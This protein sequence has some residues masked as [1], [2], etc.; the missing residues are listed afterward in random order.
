MPST[1]SR[2]RFLAAAGAAAAASLAGCAGDDA[3]DDTGTAGDAP[4]EWPTF[5]RDGRNANY[6]PSGTAPTDSPTERWRVESYRTSAQPVVADGVVYA[7]VGADVLAIDADSGERLWSV[8]PENDALRYWASPTV[9][10]GV[11]YLGDGDERLRAFDAATGELVWERTFD[12]DVFEGI[13]AAP[14]VGLRGLAVGT[15]GGTVYTLDPA[16]GETVWRT[17]VFGRIEST[18]AFDPPLFYAVT[19]G[20]DV[21]TFGNGGRGYWHVA[22]PGLSSTVPAAADGRCYVGC[23]DGKVYALAD[24]AVEWST[25]VGGFVSGGIAVAD[26]RVFV[27]GG[28]GLTVL[29]AESGD[30]R[31]SST[32]GDRYETPIVVG[33]TV[34][35]GGA[36][37][38]AVAVG[39]GIGVGAARFGAH[40]FGLS[41]SG[42]VG[43]IAAAD[44]LLVAG[45][46]EGPHDHFVAAF[47]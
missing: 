8:D 18:L 6:S 42:G 24:G 17:S 29:D 47:E 15:A 4:T 31:W 22:L 13:Y 35:V 33:E 32:V 26:G 36:G 28:T 20:G 10:D 19:N 12:D 41:F 46:S 27:A 45:V 43:H 34:Y 30:R 40:R 14:R 25:G 7:P 38:H 44:G 23:H 2:R 5:G 16:T 37:L 1:T 3:A 39:G 11:V 9:H 21:Y